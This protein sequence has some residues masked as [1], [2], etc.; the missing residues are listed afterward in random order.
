MI[1]SEIHMILSEIRLTLSEIPMILSE[2]R[3]ILSEIRLILSEIRMILSEIKVR[4]KKAE[5][6][7]SGRRARRNQSPLEERGEFK[8]RGKNNSKF[9]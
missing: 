8:V 1:L 3:M 5:K 6:S 7:K 2:I 4:G 9:G